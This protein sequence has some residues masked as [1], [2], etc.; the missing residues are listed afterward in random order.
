MNWDAIVVAVIAAVLLPLLKWGM[1]SL[2]E[3]L[4]A[5]TVRIENAEF[6]SMIQQAVD[7]VSNTVLY[8][9]QTYVDS[10]KTKGEFDALAQQEAFNKAKE[11]AKN[12]INEYAKEAI[13]L[14][15][16]DF[17]MWLDTEIEKDVHD[18]KM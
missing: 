7:T 18:Y 1:N 11:R 3:F 15:Y 2:K 6:A 16:G 14:Q 5:Q 4:K 10:L 8:V 12:L 9:M 13:E 17:S